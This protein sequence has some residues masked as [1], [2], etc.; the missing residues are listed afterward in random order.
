MKFTRVSFALAAALTFSLSSNTVAQAQLAIPD[1][2]VILRGNVN[3]KEFHS[4][5]SEM[6][7]MA[8]VSKRSDVATI[9]LHS[10]PNGS[11]AAL[12]KGDI[13][14][15]EAM[16]DE[17]ERSGVAT[18]CS[19]NFVRRKST[20][21]QS[22]DPE[23][24][25][26]WGIERIATPAA[27]ATTEGSRSVVVGVIDT[28]ID[29]A[30][31]DFDQNIWTNQD[32]VPDDGIDNDGNGYV[33]DVHGYNFIDDVSSPMDGEGHGTHVAGTI[34]ARKDNNFQVAGVSPQVSMMAVKVLDDEGSGSVESVVEGLLYAAA[35]GA[36]VVNMSLGSSDY[37]RVELVA[38]R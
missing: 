8:S 36:Q 2:V 26:L 35:N 30:H 7:A 5:V 31:P 38:L 10:S 34:G 17:L 24:Y 25:Q 28:G 16:C 19:P 33:D 14:E 29:I 23:Y 22:A 6:G 21:I 3:E 13:R 37:S 20:S 9:R 11:V 1:E 27:W 32:E 15:L 4:R 18:V 12:S